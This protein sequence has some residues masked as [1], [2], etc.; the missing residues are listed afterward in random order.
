MKSRAE[1][2]RRSRDRDEGNGGT[3][4]VSDDL[5]EELGTFLHLVL[6]PPQ[7]DDVTLL[8]WVGEIDNHLEV[9]EITKLN[10]DY[11]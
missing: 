10:P 9:G 6:R 1:R 2:R 8:R 7:L 5:L 4:Q 11:G 3:Y